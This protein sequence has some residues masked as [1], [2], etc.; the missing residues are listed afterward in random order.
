MNAMAH[1]VVLVN[2][3]DQGVRQVKDTVQRSQQ[4]EQL[5]QQL[6][7][8]T[9]MLLWTLG[10]YDLVGIF[11][12][13]DDETASAMTLRIAGQG[14]VRTETLRA[15]TAEEMSAVLGKLG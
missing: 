8:R 6:G 13:P 11:E 15:F 7:G 10:R 5:A 3:T 14:N 4:V 1:Y 9:V 12:A 2:W